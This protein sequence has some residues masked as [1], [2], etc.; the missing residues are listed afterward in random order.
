[1]VRFEG[2][3]VVVFGGA[4]GIGRAAAKGFAT[5]GA[6]VV[7]A[8]VNRAGA[9]DVARSITQTGAIA[10]GLVADIS[11][12]EEA[13]AAVK[14]AV[15]RYGRVDV[16]FNCAGVVTRRPLLEHEPGEFERVVRVNLDG[17]FNG[18]LAGARSMRELRI[19]GCIINAASVAAY[20]AT[21]GMI[22]YHASKGGVRSLTQAAALELAP[23][24]IRVVAVAPGTVDTPLLEEAK[25]AGLD[26]ELARRQM[27]RKMIAPERVADVVLFLASDQADAINGTVVLVDDGYVSFK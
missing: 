23:L 15:S 16:V 26:R 27:R 21:S 12:Y 11:R 9:D 25:A 22:S 18:I 4:G 20:V 7:V 2:R 5:E 1:M 3:V 19:H 17:T 10:I 24:G 14:E 8:D 13:E 6:S